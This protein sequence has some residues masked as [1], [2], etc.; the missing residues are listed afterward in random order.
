[1]TRA[2]GQGIVRKLLQQLVPFL[3][4]NLVRLVILIACR[5]PIDGSSFWIGRLFRCILGRGRGMRGKQA[6]RYGAERTNEW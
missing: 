1:M 2:A 4:G 5:I 6:E 3:D